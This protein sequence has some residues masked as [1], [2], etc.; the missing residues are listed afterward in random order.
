MLLVYP[1]AKFDKASTEALT[2]YNRKIG[3]ARRSIKNVLKVTKTR[4]LSDSSSKARIYF[5]AFLQV[6]FSILLTNFEM[7]DSH[8]NHF[9]LL[10]VLLL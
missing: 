5:K 10:T 4:F 8:R 2:W 3:K 1:V 7:Y 6:I 9:I